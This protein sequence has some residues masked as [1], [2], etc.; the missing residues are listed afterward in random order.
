MPRIGLDIDGV[1]ADFASSFLEYLGLPDHPADD[2]DDPRFRLNFYRIADDM[3]FWMTIKPIP[4]KKPLSFT[5]ALY[6]TARGIS[7]QLSRAWLVN[8]GFPNMPVYTV[9]VG[10]SKSRYSKK[11]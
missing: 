10:K 5:P 6:C 3:F 9:P 4:L 7:S 8:N 11:K 2:W 1:C